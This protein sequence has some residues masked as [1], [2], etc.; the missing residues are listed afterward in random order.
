MPADRVKALQVAFMKALKDPELLA[1]AKKQHLAITPLSG[2]KAEQLVKEVYAT[3]PEALA[4]MR[5]IVNSKEKLEKRT[6]K[7]QIVTGKVTK[8][9]NR[10]RFDFTLADSGKKQSSSLK[11]GYTKI[12][13]NGKKA[14]AKAVKAG[15]TCKIWYE[16]HKSTAGQVECNN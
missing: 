14:K 8:M 11:K 2:E 15:M 12:K 6:V 4:L 13:V 16:G 10:G 3:S 7:W 5:S 1:E 9:K